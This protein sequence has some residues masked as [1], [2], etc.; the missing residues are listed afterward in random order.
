MLVPLGRHDRHAADS[1]ARAGGPRCAWTPAVQPGG[2]IHDC[3]PKGTLLNIPEERPDIGT[4]LLFADA[5]PDGLRRTYFAV[6]PDHTSG[7]LLNLLRC[8]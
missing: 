6:P 1:P 8:L 5:N 3:G 2:E 4:Q 7:Q